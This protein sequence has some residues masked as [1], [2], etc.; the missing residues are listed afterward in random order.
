MLLRKVEKIKKRLG[1]SM[2][3][4]IENGEDLRHVCGVCLS[5][6]FQLLSGCGMTRDLMLDLCSQ[7]WDMQNEER[8]KN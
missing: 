2:L 4:V 1:E 6:V 7:I 3:D 8:A 5:M